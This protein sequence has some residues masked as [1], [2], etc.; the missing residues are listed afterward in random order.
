[1]IIRRNYFLTNREPRG[2]RKW[3]IWGR[4]RISRSSPY[5]WLSG[6]HFRG[7]FLGACNSI[8]LF[9]VAANGEDVAYYVV[10]SNSWAFRYQS[11]FDKADGIASA[12]FCEKFNNARP[13][14]NKLIYGLWV[15]VTRE[16]ELIYREI[17]YVGIYSRIIGSNI[18]KSIKYETSHLSLYTKIIRSIIF[19]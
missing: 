18:L 17:S 6:F 19:G 3:K 13:L 15:C 16:I 4:E 7:N 12:P 10:G 2:P 1:M 5:Y 14:S 9:F 8:K 11:V